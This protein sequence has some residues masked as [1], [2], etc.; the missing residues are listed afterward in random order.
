MSLWGG[1]SPTRQRIDITTISESLVDRQ[2]PVAG[3]AGAQRASQIA[4]GDFVVTL[5]MTL[6]LTS[7]RGALRAT[8]LVFLSVLQ[9][10][11]RRIRLLSNVLH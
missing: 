1:R 3:P 6:V 5:A 7:I 10:C 4:P 11:R 8:T 9:D 2:R